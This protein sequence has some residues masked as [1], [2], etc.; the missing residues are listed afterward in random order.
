MRCAR[1][2]FHGAEANFSRL[3]LWTAGSAGHFTM[4]PLIFFIVTA[5][6]FISA[7]IAFVPITNRNASFPDTSQN[8]ARR[9]HRR[10][11]LLTGGLLA[12]MPIF[13]KMIFSIFPLLEARVMP[14]E[15]YAAIQKDFWLPFTVLFFAFASHLVPRRNRRAV[16]IT[17]IIVFLV[18]VQ[19]TSWHLRKPP[20][21]GY[22]G[23]MVDGVCR[24]SSF[25]TCGAAA[26]TTLLNAMGIKTTE[27]EMAG[28]SMTAPGVGVSP[29]QAAYGLQRKLRQLGRPERVA[30]MVPEIKELRH[31]AKPFLAGVKFS[32]KTNHMIC[33][34]ETDEEFVVVG[35]PIS[36]GRKKWPWKRFEGFWSGIVIACL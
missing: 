1:T 36:S 7:I 26:M 8:Q 20:I 12:L 28:L 3:T 32:F 34:L 22:E 9:A 27:G 18:V 11:W 10:K 30:L 21:Y 14:I 2:Q 25:E 33:V 4:A 35:D 29:H 13:M 31:I 17:V 15:L 5:L 6:A 19:Q 23:T 24:Q 16:L